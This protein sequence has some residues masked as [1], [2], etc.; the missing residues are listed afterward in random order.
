MINITNVQYVDKGVFKMTFHLSKLVK[1]AMKVV[2]DNRE[3][4]FF[5]K[6]EIWK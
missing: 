2:L 4:L 3:N 1:M 6:H 5:K